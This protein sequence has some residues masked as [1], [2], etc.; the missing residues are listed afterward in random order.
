[1]TANTAALGPLLLVLT[2]A[3]APARPV[4]RL[5]PLPAI[6]FEQ[7][8]PLPAISPPPVLTPL[9]PPTNPGAPA[10][11]QGGI[12]PLLLQPGPVFAQPQPASPSY[13]APTLPGPID[14]QK[15]SS[16]KIWLSGQQ[17]LLERSGRSDDF[18]SR[19]IQQ[20]LLQL[21]QPGE[22]P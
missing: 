15:I 17:R 10:A 14:Q 7:L 3:G 6:P 13:P 20:Q 5:L 18:L 1:V 11:P 16:Y 9:P 12:S 22:S 19:E 4:E 21:E 2:A 8:L